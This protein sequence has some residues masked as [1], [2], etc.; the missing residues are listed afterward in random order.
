M[1]WPVKKMTDISHV[2][3]ITKTCPGCGSIFRITQNTAQ[4]YSSRICEHLHL[5]KGKGKRWS[6]NDNTIRKV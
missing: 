4:K 5:T 1:S 2:K 3:L 6:S